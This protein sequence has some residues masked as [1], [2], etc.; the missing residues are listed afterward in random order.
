MFVTL[1]C[2][3]STISMQYAEVEVERSITVLHY[4][5]IPKKQEASININI[6]LL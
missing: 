2:S 4:C 5:T 6:N 3:N 1:Y